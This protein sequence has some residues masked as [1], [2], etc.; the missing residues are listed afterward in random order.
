MNNAE[1]SLRLWRSLRALKLATRDD[2][3][4]WASDLTNSEQSNQTVLRLAS[5]F[6]DEE[7][8]VDDILLSDA[9]GATQQTDYESGMI[10]ALH[11]AHQI[12]AGSITA[13]EGIRLLW[14][15]SSLVPQTQRDLSVFIG[16]ESDWNENPERGPRYSEETLRY[17]KALVD[18]H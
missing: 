9:E 12:L 18:S 8:L 10:A 15:V 4:R 13:K 11:F 2:I 7:Q 6:R 3:V 5:L 14:R 1:Q 17:A 16:I